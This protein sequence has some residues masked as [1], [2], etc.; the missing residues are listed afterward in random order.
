[1]QSSFG[2][3]NFHH[4]AT[5]WSEWATKI[6]HNP[7]KNN[8]HRQLFDQVQPIL[9]C[10]N[11]SIIGDGSPAIWRKVIFNRKRIKLIQRGVEKQK[12]R[13][14]PGFSSPW[15][16]L[17]VIPRSSFLTLSYLA[18]ASINLAT[19]S[20]FQTMFLLKLV[21]ILSLRVQIDKCLFEWNISNWG[22][23]C[24]V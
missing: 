19:P 7:G 3:N 12:I 23:E 24:E 4:T 9:L 13:K 5:M 18:L 11:Y 14:N 17:S 1:M 16:V 10:R 20:S 6:L 2:E 15:Q 22:D 8:Q 21:W